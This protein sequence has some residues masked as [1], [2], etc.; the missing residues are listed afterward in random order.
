[1][2]QALPLHPHDDQPDAGPG[3]GQTALGSSDVSI[4]LLSTTS[5]R[6]GPNLLTRCPMDV[7]N[8]G[9]PRRISRPLEP[10]S[11]ADMSESSTTISTT[12]PLVLRARKLR[13]E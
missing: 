10:R 7:R 12:L 11:L 8:V 9:S 1:M 6:P 5:Y 3:V 2:S 4:S 13:M